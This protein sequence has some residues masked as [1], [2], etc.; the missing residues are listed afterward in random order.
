MIN[1]INAEEDEMKYDS[2]V[3][4]II[5]KINSSRTSEKIK[6]NLLVALTKIEKY[7]NAPAESKELLK[8]ILNKK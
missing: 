4:Y 2:A 5:D 1:N 8:R 6:L 3:Q 7:G